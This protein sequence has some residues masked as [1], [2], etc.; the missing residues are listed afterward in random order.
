[1]A[2]SLQIKLLNLLGVVDRLGINLF[3][4][5]DYCFPNGLLSFLKCDLEILRVFNG[6][7]C[8][9]DFDLLKEIS[10]DD[11]FIWLAL[12][13]NRQSLRLNDYLEHLGPG[14]LGYLNLHVNILNTLRPVVLICLGSIV[15]TD[16]LVYLDISLDT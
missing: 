9:I 5:D 4:T 8:L 14:S 11:W 7:E 13:S 12:Q 15:C 6:P 16:C 3:I 10:F 2:L 1:M